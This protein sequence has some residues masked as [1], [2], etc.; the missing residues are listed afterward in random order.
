MDQATMERACAATE[1]IVE[2][3]RPEHHDL[4][5]PCSEWTARLLLNHLV[6]T[7]VIHSACLRDQ[8]PAVGFD[9]AGQPD[10]DLLG[11]D[12]LKA[13][14]AGAEQL[15]AAAGGGALERIHST[16]MGDLPGEAQAS[17]VMMDV[18]VHG[19]DL[20]SA[21]GVPFVLDDDIAR[22]VLAFVRQAIGDPMR[23]RHLGPEV[24]VGAGASTVDQ[25]VAFLGRTP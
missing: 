6:G 21:I 9:D 1:R 14:R 15:V 20:A 13:Y 24:T 25:L 16:P 11:D 8:A 18:V 17:F 23:R 7:L 2:A 10:S 22:E 4:P 3:M 19:W 5:T 12:P